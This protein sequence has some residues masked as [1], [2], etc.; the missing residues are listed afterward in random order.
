MNIDDLDG[1]DLDTLIAQRVFNLQVESRTNPR[2]GEKDFVYALSPE[3]SSDAWGSG[4]YY[5]SG[6]AGC[7]NVEVEL[8][9]HG[10]RRIDGNWHDTGSDVT[11]ILRHADG[12]EVEATGRVNVAV[13]RAALKAVPQ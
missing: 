1:R 9:K 4:P 6:L 8:Q 7:I 10:W 12:R 13:S 11:V 3:T 2:T 5:S